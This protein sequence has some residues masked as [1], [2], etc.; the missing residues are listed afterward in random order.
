VA[1]RNTLTARVTQLEAQIAQTLTL[2]NVATKSST[3]GRKGQT[4]PEKFTWEDR[5]KLRSFVALLHLH[6]IDRPGEFP[7]E[8]SK[9]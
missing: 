5:G 7:N 3:A 4:D 9:L 1:D 8:R 2:A 6:L